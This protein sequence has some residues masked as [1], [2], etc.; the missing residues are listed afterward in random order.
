[1]DEIPRRIIAPAFY[2]THT[3]K[4]ASAAQILSSAPVRIA[5]EIVLLER[6]HAFPTTAGAAALSSR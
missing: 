5:I 2:R 1:M 3:N 4:H 6:I